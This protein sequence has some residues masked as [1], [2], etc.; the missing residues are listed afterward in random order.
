MAALTPQAVN[1]T[2]ATPSYTAISASDTVTITGL[3]PAVWLHIKN[4]GGSPNTCTVVDAGVSPA[5]NS[6]VDDAYTI[7]A[8]TGDKLIRLKDVLAADGVI[9][10]TNSATTGGTCGVFYIA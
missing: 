2:G 1:D 9:T 6:G 8:T 3:G 4:T 5:G 7:P 10:I